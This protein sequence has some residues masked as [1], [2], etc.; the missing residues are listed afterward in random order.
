MSE[1]AWGVIPTPAVIAKEAELDLA[2]TSSPSGLLLLFNGVLTKEGC[3]HN[4]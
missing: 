3:I 2:L 1:K 4:G